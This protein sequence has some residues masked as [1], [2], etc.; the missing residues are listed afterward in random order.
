MKRLG[1]RAVYAPGGF[2]LSELGDIEVVADGDQLHLFHLTLPSHDVVQHAVSRDGLRWDPM[3]AAL[4][5]GDPG[6]CDDDQIWTMSV[7]RHDNRWRMLYTALALAEN[8][9]VQRTALAISDDLVRWK[10]SA[11]NPV[12]EADPRWYETDPDEWGAVSWRDPKPIRVGNRWYALVAARQR[13]GPLLRRGCVGLLTSADFD[14]WEVLPPLF[15]PR[16]FWDLEC[17]QA[18]EI[19]GRWYLTAAVMEDRRQRYWRAPAFGGPWDEPG[20]DGYLAPGGHYAGRIGRWNG[21]DLLWCWHQ[22]HLG[23][24]WTTSPK[25]VDWVAPRNPYGKWLAP[26]LELVP[27]PDGSLARRSF[28]GWAA[29][30]QG[31]LVPA[32]PAAETHFGRVPVDPASGWRVD[33]GGSMEILASIAPA[34]DCLIEGEIALSGGSGGLAFRL[35]RDGGGYF[36]ELRP[37][38]AAVSLQKWLTAEEAR[39]G[40]REH[41]WQELQRA[42]LMMPFPAGTAMP[43]R[44]LV[45]GPYIE[46]SFGGEAVLATFSGERLAGRWGIWAGSGVAAGTMRFASLRKP[47]A[48]RGAPG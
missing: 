41:V 43:F 10:K 19:G 7:A 46:V 4:R 20:D 21:R 6:A 29:Y 11:A 18:F 24:G 14:R 13:S 45:V 36:V 1:E 40:R 34:E 35:D 30:Q 3:P 17:P 47:W 31:P 22:A 42:D 26:P 28:A 23:E 5:T 12:A 48:D 37:G 39:S 44:L 32:A 2:G 16:R 33:G 15:A 25:T 8:G 27:R 9:A 38:S